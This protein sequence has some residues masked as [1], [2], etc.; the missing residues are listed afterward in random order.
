ATAGH[1]VARLSR[2]VQDVGAR[3]DRLCTRSLRA[4]TRAFNR[5]RGRARLCAR[6]PVRAPAQADGGVGRLLQQAGA[7]GSGYR[8]AAPSRAMKGVKRTEWLTELCGGLVVHWKQCGIPAEEQLTQ[9]L[10]LPKVD[11]LIEAAFEYHGL[12][13]ENPTHW[14]L[15]LLFMIFAQSPPKP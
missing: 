11:G 14:K 4:S 1:H 12:N 10:S 15:L 2:Y 9:I 7:G 3:A 6:R 13:R 8:S 5:Q